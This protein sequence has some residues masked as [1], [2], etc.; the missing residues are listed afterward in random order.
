MQGFD[1]FVGSFDEICRSCAEGVLDDYREGQPD[2]HHI[3]FPPS[4]SPSHI[5]QLG[6]AVT[7][8]TGVEGDFGNDSDRRELEGCLF[9][10][11]LTADWV[12]A[13]SALP[14]DVA[15][16]LKTRWTAACV[17]DEGEEP[18]WAQ[19]A[20]REVLV[21]FLALCKAAAREK[22]DLVMVWEL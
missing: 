7:S 21:R 1:L 5:L 9:A 3:A 17:A 2:D 11:R 10:D 12:L 18:P 20:H 6:A 16:E 14:F 19:E 8:L 13:T 22:S 15:E 4:F